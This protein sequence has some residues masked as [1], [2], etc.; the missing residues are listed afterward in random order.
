MWIRVGFVSLTGLVVAV[1]STS[2]EPY[3][4]A[5]RLVLWIGALL[6]TA[7]LF[8]PRRYRPPTVCLAALL[9]GAVAGRVLLEAGMPRVHDLMHLWG[10]W[11]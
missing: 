2:M 11:S 1:A 6:A 9:L 3:F 10:I 5:S 8:A 7:G 4:E